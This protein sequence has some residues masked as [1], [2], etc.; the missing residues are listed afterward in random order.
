MKNL[1]CVWRNIYNTARATHSWY[2]KHFAKHA[3]DFSLRGDFLWQAI[4]GLPLCYDEKVVSLSSH[5]T[6]NHCLRRRHED[7]R[8]IFVG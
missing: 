1:T 5:V 8:R 7:K 4:Y 2:Y 6:V 3:C